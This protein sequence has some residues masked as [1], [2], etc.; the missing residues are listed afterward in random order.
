MSTF[1]GT[2]HHALPK[3]YVPV[4]TSSFRESPIVA[5]SPFLK[6]RR[7]S[8]GGDLWLNKNERIPVG[9]AHEGNAS[10]GTWGSRTENA[11]YFGIVGPNIKN[12]PTKDESISTPSYFS[13]FS[14]E[15][16]PNHRTVFDNTTNASRSYSLLS[17]E[18]D[19]RDRSWGNGG[20][21]RTPVP[22]FFISSPSDVL[23]VT[24]P[25]SSVAASCSVKSSVKKSS[26]MEP[27]SNKDLLKAF[28]SKSG[29][30]ASP[31]KQTHLAADAVS[32]IQANSAKK[33]SKT[34]PKS[35]TERMKDFHSNLQMIESTQKQKP[36]AAGALSST[37]RPKKAI[38]GTMKRTPTFEKV[39]ESQSYQLDRAAYENCKLLGMVS[40]LQG[41]LQK[42]DQ[43]LVEKDGMIAR[44][45]SEVA[46]LQ[47][48][49]K[50]TEI[51]NLQT[52]L[53]CHQNEVASVLLPSKPD[54]KSRAKESSV[55]PT[56]RV[57]RSMARR[58]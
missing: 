44:L 16:T 8:G 26:N 58:G 45:K 41:G 48:Q 36:P 20:L 19:G 49:L 47:L 33:A 40:K 14:T 29:W 1:P 28:Q 31:Q 17:P 52:Q 23:V 10:T 34:K 43:V 5:S 56:K 18:T 7:G 13:A 30:I 21:D 9:V 2:Q 11:G 15:K 39:L 12:A 38:K 51:S 42:K 24:S 4:D 55:P 6:K 3:P 37:G 53:R 32:S 54:T 46:A 35:K 25:L 50:E 57:T 27:E 22:K